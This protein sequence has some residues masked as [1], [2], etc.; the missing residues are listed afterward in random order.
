LIIQRDPEL[1]P[2]IQYRH[3]G[4]FARWTLWLVQWGTES[5][6]ITDAAQRLVEAYPGSTFEQVVIP[7][8][9]GPAYQT[10]VT[11]QTNPPTTVPTPEEPEEP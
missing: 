9:F 7:V 6:L 4:A 8:G 10:R 5:G 3:P 11:L 1:L 2:I